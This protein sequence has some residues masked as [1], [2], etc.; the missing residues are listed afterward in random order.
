MSKTKILVVDD[1]ESIVML[2]KK[3]LT[4]KGYEVITASD[5]A[6]GLRLARE[7][8]P[9]LIILDVML[10]HM[11]GYSICRLLKYD[12]K[13]EQIPII[14]LTSRSDKADKEIGQATGAN[15]YL[16]KPFNEEALLASVAQL[17]NS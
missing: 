2:L 13:Y 3:A 17:L 8:N 11:D 9:N 10:P 6:E 7:S 12:E 1:S 14:M 15:M 4:K 5:G 16:V